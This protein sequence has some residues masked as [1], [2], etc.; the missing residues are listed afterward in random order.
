MFGHP[1][2][3]RV[4]RHQLLRSWIQSARSQHSQHS[5]AYSF[6]SHAGFILVGLETVADIGHADSH[7]GIIRSAVSVESYA[8]AVATTLVFSLIPVWFTLIRG[9]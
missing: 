7:L 9:K 8:L 6:I 5:F 2:F 4:R 3:T 1:T